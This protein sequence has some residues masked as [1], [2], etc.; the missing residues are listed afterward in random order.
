MEK[1]TLY[2]E[3]FF[4]KGNLHTHSTRSDGSNSPK[5]IAK[6]YKESGYDFLAI[7]DHWVYGVHEDLNSEEFLLFPGTELDIETPERKDHHIV[8]IGLPDT[9]K[10]PDAYTF[11]KERFTNQ[12]STPERI[13]EYFGQKGNATIYAHPYWSKV[14]SSDIKYLQGI[15]G[16]EIYNHGSEFESNNGNSET[17]YDHFLFVRNKTFCFATDDAHDLLPH[18]LGGFIVVKTKEFS[19]RGILQAIKDG[20]F[21]ASS[22]PLIKDFYVEDILEDDLRKKGYQKRAKVFC[23]PCKDIYLKTPHTNNHI[24][25]D[26]NKLTMGEFLLR[27]DEEYVRIVLK[28]EKGQ[29]A[30]SQPIWLWLV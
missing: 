15:L 4:K 9:N 1:R 21:Y 8:A 2:K 22:G 20:S 17:Y 29:K 14:D 10:I 28:D 19:H 26:G 7:T 24:Y 5:E 30:W 27:G 13:I 12:L 3:G 25:S 6:V 18:I 23:A 11:E 16:I